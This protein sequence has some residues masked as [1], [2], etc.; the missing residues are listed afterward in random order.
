MLHGSTQRRLFPR[1]FTADE[2]ARISAA[3]LLIVGDHERVYRP[4]VVKRAVLRLLRS[5]LVEISPNAHH[6][7]AVAQPAAVSTCLMRFRNGVDSA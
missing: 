4:D 5:V 7:A 1:V 2:L 3:T 6:V